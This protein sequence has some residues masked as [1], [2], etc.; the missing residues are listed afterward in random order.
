MQAAIYQEFKSIGFNQIARTG[1]IL[2]CAEKS[3]FNLHLILYLIKYIRKGKTHNVIL[4]NIYL[5]LQTTRKEYY[6]LLFASMA[7]LGST[8]SVFSVDRLAFTTAQYGLLLTTNGIIAAVFQYPVAI[9]MNK[10]PRYRGLILGSILYAI[11]YTSFGWVKSFDWGLVSMAIITAGEITFSPI[12]SS[13]IAE[14]APL[15]G[16]D[17]T[18][19]LLV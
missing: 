15:I 1:N 8:L 17:A 2:R 11:G 4:A 14:S 3:N 5:T 7:Q 9:W 13:V 10:F 19:D 16:A 18:W 6:I 12:A